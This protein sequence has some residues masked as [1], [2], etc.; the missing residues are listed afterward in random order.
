MYQFISGCLFTSAS[1]QD[2]ARCRILNHNG[3]VVVIAVLHNGRVGR[4]FGK[5]IAE[6]ALVSNVVERDYRKAAAII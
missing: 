6:Q 2:I 5:Q 4:L 1:V 3:I